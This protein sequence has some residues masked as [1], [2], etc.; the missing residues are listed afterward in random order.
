MTT[1][2]PVPTASRA[3]SPEQE[4]LDEKNRQMSILEAEYASKQLDYTTLAG[5][6]AAFRNRYF[7]R[8]ATLYAQLDAIRAEVTAQ[9]SR[10][11][12]DDATAKQTAE[13][14]RRQAE[15][16]SR[17]LGGA[18]EDEP[19]SFTPSDELKQL[20][21]QAAK[22]IHPDRALNEEDRLLRDR[23]MA[24]INKAYE[25]GDADAILEITEK[26]RDRLSSDDTED[27]GTRLVRVIRLI[28]KT[29]D[30]IASLDRAIDEL[31]VSEWYKLKVDIEAR[32]S[33]GEDPL[34]QLAEKIQTDILAEQTRLRELFTEPTADRD[35]VK[36]SRGEETTRDKAADLA[37]FA[38]MDYGVTQSDVYCYR[39][40]RGDMVKTQSEAVIA[41]ELFSQGIDYCYEYPVE[42]RYRPGIRRPS[43]LAFDARRE[44][45][46]W[47][48]LGTLTG[49]DQRA[50]WA[51]KLDWFEA[52]GF[53]QNAN[54]FITR[55][56]E[57]GSIDRRV[58]EKL[59]GKIK[60]RMM[61]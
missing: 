44:P 13:Q 8:V 47:Q 3:K 51:A 32:E 55:D 36:P 25:S 45:I 53:A 39:A 15:E 26:Y 33:E 11:A 35:F 38:G 22:L 19:I 59:A 23:L 43:F 21:R 30:R 9:L 28:A 14:A 61:S 42:G 4:E 34:A 29:R 57:N 20:Y 56:R 48:H 17:E 58:I 16:T 50:Q 40:E 46:L 41:N 49:A 6:V 18:D 54:L 10:L 27:I 12:P 52:N 60:S 31:R 7:L 24:D 5:E 37:S 2:Y 1:R